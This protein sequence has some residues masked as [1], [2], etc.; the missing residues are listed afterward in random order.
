MES[1][2]T[3]KKENENP[4]LKRPHSKQEQE[5]YCI[6][7]K[8]H[9]LSEN[10]ILKSENTEI[11]D[12]KNEV[13]NGDVKNHVDSETINS[14]NHTEILTEETESQSLN[15][16]ES[17]DILTEDSQENSQENGDLL[18]NIGSLSDADSDDSKTEKWAHCNDPRTALAFLQSEMHEGKDPYEILEEVIGATMTANIKNRYTDDGANPYNPEDADMRPWKLRKS[19]E[20]VKSF[21]IWP[22]FNFQI[23]KAN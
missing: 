18:G 3:D 6:D 19:L 2:T 1:G 22:I 11:G 16:Q 20:K 5:E 4:S 15:S 21:K 10:A 14:E 23:I 7:N 12:S 9:K 8:Q 17:Q 13:N